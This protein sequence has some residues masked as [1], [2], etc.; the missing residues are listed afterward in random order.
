MTFTDEQN[1]LEQVRRDV[2][3]GRVRSFY[4]ARSD[5]LQRR[6]DQ[7]RHVDDGGDLSSEELVRL[8]ES[9]ES[10]RRYIEAS[11]DRGD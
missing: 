7:W 3:N 4:D 2:E 10:L 1:W 9:A 6:K 8:I 5:D 11:R